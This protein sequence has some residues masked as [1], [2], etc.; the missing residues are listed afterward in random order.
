MKSAFVYPGQGAS[1]V[2]GMGREVYEAF[3]LAR[4]VFQEVNESLS[5]DLTK[6]IFDGPMDE[7]S[8]TENAQPALMTVSVALTRVLLQESGKSLSDMASCVAGH[9]LGEYS[10][11]CAA[12]VFS[13]ADTAQ[14]LKT[15]GKA[16][17]SAVPVGKGAMAAVIGMDFVDVEGVAADASSGDVCVVA[18]D[19]APGQ[20]VIS[21]DALAVERAMALA[22]E[23]GARKSVALPVSAPFHC[24][25]MQPASDVMAEAL[26]GVQMSKPLVP[27]MANVTAALTSNPEEIRDL[28][29]QQVTG[30]VRWRESVTNMEKDGVEQVVEIGSGKVL[31]GLVRRIAPDLKTVN[32]ATPQDIEDFLKTL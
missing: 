4:E 30:Q 9:S 14:L 2:Q 6:L 12:G 31:T 23:R 29:I 17:Q 27:L 25:L 11:L 3:P 15:R 10:A 5:Q 24:P 18:N 21:G 19:N 8:L 7:L 1:L 32:V 28:L 13:L 22:S 16:M 20:V 26:A